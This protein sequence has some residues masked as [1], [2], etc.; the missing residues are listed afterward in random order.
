MRT[1]QRVVASLCVA[2]CLILAAAGAGRAINQ[3]APARITI[4]ADRALGP[5]SPQLF[6]QTASTGTNTAPPYIAMYGQLGI[7]LLAAPGGQ[8]G[9]ASDLSP[10]QV[11]D[12]AALAGTLNA[13]VALRP[14]LGRAGAPEKAANLVRYANIER[15]YGFRTWEI[16]NEPDR[17]PAAD[18]D[19]YNIQFR[20]FTLAMKAVDP[21]IKV[22]GPAVGDDWMTWLPAFIATNGDIADVLSWRWV[23]PAGELTEAQLLATP[24]QIER[25]VQIIR[26]WW[27]TPRS[28]PKAHLQPV[29]PLFLSA[30]AASRD[31][32]AQSPLGNEAGAL[33]AAEVVGRLANL[34]V[35]MASYPAL[36]GAGWLGLIGDGLTP[37]PAYGVFRLYSQWGQTQLAAESPDA[38]LLPAFASRR[39]DGALAVLMLNKDPQ[40][41]RPIELAFTG[42]AAAGQAEVWQQDAA[43]PAG[44]KL[45]ALRFTE[46]LAAA[47]PPYSATLFIIPAAQPV[48]WPLWVGL[49]LGVATAFAI[50]MEL[51][52]RRANRELGTLRDHVRDVT[53]SR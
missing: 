4:R 17:D 2:G 7:G 1:F 50:I 44:Q 29:P 3:A 20:D 25:Q 5:V 18:V 24:P 42:F 11:D 51:E 26:E 9:D 45:E 27:R 12:L 10:E 16:G 46:I 48:V 32:G 52:E 23:P 22:A 47:L 34:G 14:Q 13:P 38:A 19:G 53:D 15:G 36:Q 39:A 28:N 49:F 35:E 31:T 33:W 6:G 30:Y 40:Q 37:R 41:A 43:H 8:E 21:S